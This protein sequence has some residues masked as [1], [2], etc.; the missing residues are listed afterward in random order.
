MKKIISISALAFCTIFFLMSSCK[1][2]DGDT[3][4][5]TPPT[6]TGTKATIAGLIV[7]ESNNP[8]N[9][10]SV[11]I[12]NT[13]V[14][15]NQFGVFMFNG[16]DVNENRTVLTVTKG[17][18]IKRTHAFIPSTTSVNY[19]K[20]MLQ[21]RNSSG[22]FNGASSQTI[23]LTDGSQV[24]FQANSIVT[25]AGAAYTGTVTV[26]L[27][28]L[29]ESNPDF[30]FLIPGGDLAGK[31]TAGQDVALISYGM[32]GVF[33]EGSNGEAL[34][35]D[36]LKPATIK[37]PIAATQIASAPA[38][39]SLWYLDDATGKWIEQ[40]TAT[41]SGSNYI[42]TVKHFSWWNCDYPSPWATI[43][44]RVVDCDGNPFPNCVVT[45]NGVY[46][47]TT[48]SNGEYQG[49]VPTGIN[50]TIQVLAAN[51]PLI[52]TNSAIINVA[53]LTINQVYTVTDITVNCLTKI[54]GTL[55]GCNSQ[56]V[57][58][59]VLLV[60]NGNTISY[61]FTPNSNFML[62][63][64]PST[65]YSLSAYLAGNSFV[66]STQIVTSGFQ[67]DTN[68]VGNVFL[69]GSTTGVPVNG[70]IT[71]DTIYG[72]NTFTVTNA[73]AIGKVDSGFIPIRVEI[74]GMVPPNIITSLNL[75]LNDT[76][77]GTYSI[78]GTSSGCGF[79]INMSD[80]FN[81]STI[82]TY[83]PAAFGTIILTEVG[84]IGGRIKGSY[85]GIALKQ[86]PL[87]TDTT[88]IQCTFDVLRTY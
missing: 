35:I 21:Y 84:N 62:P 61:Q 36:S 66:S 69:C 81:F 2:N 23:N 31:N 27:K 3:L 48:N 25:S 79:Y 75:Y 59:L 34:Q 17:G 41:K 73:T 87:N 56:N 44:G 43:K 18:Y 28:H 6:P 72:I 46:T 12:G 52:T 1:K 13:T 54:S 19:L 29:S 24:Q 88:A 9:G 7:D 22:T 53:P 11:M 82:S 70:F 77:L 49:N 47:L 8:L 10:A 65:Q 64:L 33:L 42:G 83:D 37:F 60:E 16:V 76:I 51:N 32:L 78:F 14:T 55:K 39:I 45:F 20:L 26:T 57:N 63:C 71:S 38:T 67:G 40:G 15:T 30:G 68:N 80:S 85:S 50:I 4:D 5:N 86:T 58:G 74:N